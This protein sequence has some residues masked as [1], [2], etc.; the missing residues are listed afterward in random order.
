MSDPVTNAE[1][2]DVLS[3]IRRLVSEDK[4][5][6]PSPKPAGADRLVLTPALR[7]AEPPQP[8][9][10]D[11][12]SE[13][14][15]AFVF[16]EPSD[17]DYVTF[18]DGDDN[19]SESES[20]SSETTADDA[21][22]MSYDE[23]IADDA[24]QDAQS[25]LAQS[26][27]ARSVDDEDEERL[28]A[29]PFDDATVDEDDAAHDDKAHVDAAHVDAAHVDAAH[30]DTAHDD[31][32]KD[33]AEQRDAYR[34]E[35]DR[36]RGDD[37][38][39]EGSS[40]VSDNSDPV[41]KD[42]AAL[43]AKIAALETAIGRIPDRWEPDGDD[44]GPYAGTEAASA[45]AWEDDVELDATGSPLDDGAAFRRDVEEIEE[46]KMDTGPADEDDSAVLGAIPFG[47]DD[48]FLDEDALRDLVSDIVRAELQGALGERITRNVRKLVRRE[49][50][51]A[52][53][54]Q[55]LE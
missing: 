20:V 9:T 10:A 21:A 11:A 23:E 27:F 33:D 7:V 2:E 26:G 49:I 43:G 39:E 15:D 36:A 25:G 55:E 1:V 37:A 35:D 54:A 52:L 29:Q 22:E 17:R 44:T 34:H 46:A 30:D 45:M 14:R 32:N 4:R 50:H 38:S 8:D 12:W 41:A 42:K 24:A 6:K 5:P 28:L 13:K 31:T 47:N 48:Q 53:T 18:D 16:V 51:R 40:T 3:S 19:H